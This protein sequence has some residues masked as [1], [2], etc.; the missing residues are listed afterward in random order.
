MASQEDKDCPGILSAAKEEKE[1]E[2]RVLG[3]EESNKSFASSN[4]K[5]TTC[6][7]GF[8]PSGRGG[9]SEEF[10]RGQN[11]VEG[12]R[13]PFDSEN[14]GHEKKIVNGDDGN[15]EMDRSGIQERGVPHDKVS[16]ECGTSKE[17]PKVKVQVANEDSVSE[18]LLEVKKKILLEE[19]EAVL[20]PLGEFS[21]EKVTGCKMA[22]EDFPIPRSLGIEVIDDTALIE[23][24]PAPVKGKKL[25]VLGYRKCT[26]KDAIKEMDVRNGKRSRRKA[27]GAKNVCGMDGKNKNVTGMDEAQNLYADR[28][29]GTKR[30]Y[31]RKEIE[32][33]RFVNM[34]EQ[35]EIWKA[36]YSGLDTAVAGE[37]DNLVASSEHQKHIRLNYEPQHFFAKNKEA[38][39]VFSAVCCENIDNELQQM[40]SSENVNPMDPSCGLSMGKDGCAVLEEECTKDSDSE[41]D[42]DSIQKPAFLVNGE[43][44]FDLGPPEDGWEYLRRVRQT[45]TLE[46]SKGSSRQKLEVRSPPNEAC[47]V[48]GISSFL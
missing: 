11:I 20:L 34:V 5:I 33:V 29:D 24:I 25:D 48:V 19:L 39:P 32:A 47:V 12:M 15:K 42:Y 1:F 41:D 35:R 43:P 8:G 3:A 45:V 37:Y 44:N 4:E 21:G 2:T 17:K 18:N 30:K 14:L 7:S 38:P 22:Q 10:S 36:I 23:T 13:E 9:N 27:K 31:S 16:A 26:G 40:D 28:K 46:N 6:I